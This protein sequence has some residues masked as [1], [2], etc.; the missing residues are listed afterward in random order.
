MFLPFNHFL[1]YFFSFFLG[2]NV[3]NIFLFLNISFMF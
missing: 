1:H 3:E 2:C